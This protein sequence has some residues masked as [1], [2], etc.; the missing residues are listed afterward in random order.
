M[1]THDISSVEYFADE[2]AVM[3]RGAVV[4]RGPTADVLTRPRESYT[5]Q[6]LSARLLV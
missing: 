3:Y 4:E 6:L 1:I 5:E 2:V